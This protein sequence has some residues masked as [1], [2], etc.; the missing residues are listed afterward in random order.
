M[1][2]RVFDLEG[3][4]MQNEHKKFRDEVE[5]QTAQ[6][7]EAVQKL[8]AELAGL[9]QVL[10]QKN[11]RIYELEEEVEKRRLASGDDLKRYQVCA[12]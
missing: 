10:V 9:Q 7:A 12:S 6:H 3:M 4:C 11:T 2:C 5:Q 8:E 1:H